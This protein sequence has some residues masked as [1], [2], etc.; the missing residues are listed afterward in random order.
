MRK[1]AR[2]A[3]LEKRFPDAPA[4]TAFFSWM[5]VLPT[6]LA[7]ALSF[8]WPGKGQQTG[9]RYPLAQNSDE[10]CPPRVHRRTENRSPLLRYAAIGIG[11]GHSR[12]RLFVAYAI[13]GQIRLSPT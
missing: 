12:T 9:R 7:D 13:I 8:G 11:A 3:E 1:T 6:A 5:A 2:A 4:S 10:L